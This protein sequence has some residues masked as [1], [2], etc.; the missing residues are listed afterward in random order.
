[1]S[2]YVILADVGL[3][4][5]YGILLTHLAR[6][7]DFMY[8]AH[9]YEMRFP[10]ERAISN[11][12]VQ[13][14]QIGLLYTALDSSQIDLRLPPTWLLLIVALVGAVGSIAYHT[15]YN[16]SLCCENPLATYWGFPFSWLYGI[17]QDPPFAP[18]DQWTAYTYVMQF[19][20]QMRWRIS[21]WKVAA[22]FIFWWNVIFIGCAWPLGLRLL[23]TGIKHLLALRYRR[24]HQRL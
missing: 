22:N 16:T 23:T 18:Y 10:L 24:L 8:Q 6:S 7:A 4:L 17:A 11:L 13:L 15:V 1:M 19:S 3:L 2:V 12:L 5:A 21:A 20:G 9:P 14:V